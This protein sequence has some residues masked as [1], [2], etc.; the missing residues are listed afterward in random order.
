MYPLCQKY[1]VKSPLQPIVT[2]FEEKDIFLAKLLLCH[3]KKI[4]FDIASP[5]NLLFI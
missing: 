1:V 5:V 2:L 4:K 3:E